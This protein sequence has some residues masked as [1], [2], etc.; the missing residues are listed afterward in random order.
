[1]QCCIF[2]LFVHIPRMFS[3]CLEIEWRK[4]IDCDFF[5]D[6]RGLRDNALTFLIETKAVFHTSPSGLTDR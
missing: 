4:V 1:M 3:V 5:L 2:I 6:G